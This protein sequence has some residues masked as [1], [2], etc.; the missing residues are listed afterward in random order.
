MTALTAFIA[1]SLCTLALVAVA[2]ATVSRGCTRER[3]SLDA[4]R[5]R[6]RGELAKANAALAVVT[7]ERDDARSVACEWQRVHQQDRS[8]EMRAMPVLFTRR[9]RAPSRG[10]A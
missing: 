1:G 10:T 3:D 9:G 6:L 4:D 7:A 8:R 5:A 2:R